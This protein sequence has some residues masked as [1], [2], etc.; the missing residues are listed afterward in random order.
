[1]IRSVK[2]KA[3]GQG[4]ITNAKDSSIQCQVC[5]I[6]LGNCEQLYTLSE[7]RA[8]GSAVII[9]TDFYQYDEHWFFIESFPS[10]PA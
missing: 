3:L 7:E 10:L 5:R 6:L 8:S 9:G 4:F 1:M 2:L